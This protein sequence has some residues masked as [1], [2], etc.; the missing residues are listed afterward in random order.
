MYKCKPERNMKQVFLLM[1]VSVLLTAGIFTLSV[2][3]QKSAGLIRFIGF[4][5][6]A[7][8]VY[9]IYRFTMTETEY[10]LY[11]GTFTV[12]RIV[13]NKRTDVAVIDLADAEALVPKKEFREKGLNKGL[14][15]ITNYSQNIGGDHWVLVFA[16]QEKRASVEFEP[17]EAFVAIFKTEIENAKNRPSGSD[18]L[19]V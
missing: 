19:P 14:S 6:L 4:F 16:F 13:G 15:V 18:G 9:V 3:I 2:F 10:T 17:N 5:F 1:G 8:C 12:T 7:L 11:D